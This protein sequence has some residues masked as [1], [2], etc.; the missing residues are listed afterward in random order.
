MRQYENEIKRA[1]LAA[2]QAGW[3][4]THGAWVDDV[5]MRCCALGACLV[6][7]GLDTT[8]PKVRIRELFD[9]SYSEIVAF[10]DGFDGLSHTVFPAYNDTFLFGKEIRS[11][12]LCHA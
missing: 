8:D 9:V 3:A 7:H 4:I 5:N 2:E 1:I 10:T 6:E 12:A 11:W